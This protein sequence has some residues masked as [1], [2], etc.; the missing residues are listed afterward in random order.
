M[1]SGS[2]RPATVFMMILAY[3]SITGFPF[4]ASFPLKVSFLSLSFSQ[5][6]TIGG[7]ASAGCLGENYKNG[8]FMIDSTLGEGGHSYAVSRC[9][10]YFHF[11]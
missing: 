4:L 8:G 3:F 5:S 9:R 6:E 2:N 7:L 11:L 10:P 1:G